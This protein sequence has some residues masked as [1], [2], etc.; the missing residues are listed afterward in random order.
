M[1]SIVHV[2]NRSLDSLELQ[3]RAESIIENLINEE[4]SMNNFKN[5]LEQLSLLNITE[6]QQLNVQSSSKVIIWRPLLLSNLLIKLVGPLLP[7]FLKVRAI[8]RRLS[9]WRILY[10]SADKLKV[11]FDSKYKKKHV[12]GNLEKDWEN[13]TI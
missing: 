2:L 10:F 6:L 12:Y 11:Y 8:K 1:A 4:F 5:G 9:V 13:G 3:Y 7:L